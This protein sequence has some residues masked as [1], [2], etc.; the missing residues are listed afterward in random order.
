MPQHNTGFVHFLKVSGPPLTVGRSGKEKSRETK[1]GP[2]W[3]KKF[4][5]KVEIA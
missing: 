1:K 5:K 2:G 4:C 3:R